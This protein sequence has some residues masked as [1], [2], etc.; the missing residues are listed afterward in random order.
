[1]I[2]NT[3]NYGLR[4]AFAKS[5][6]YKAGEANQDGTPAASFDSHFFLIPPCDTTAGVADAPPTIFDVRCKEVF[7]RSNDAANVAP[8]SL[9][10]ALTGIESFPTLTGSNGFKG[11]G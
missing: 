11:V 7:L 6:S 10:A 8:F 5:G 2:K 3:G 4:V 1:M 9:Y